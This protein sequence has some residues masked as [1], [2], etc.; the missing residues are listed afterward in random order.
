[1]IQHPE[2][3]IIPPI[4]PGNQRSPAAAPRRQQMNGLRGCPVQR[5]VGLQRSRYD[6]VRPL[7]LVARVSVRRVG[8]EE[9]AQAPP[10]QRLRVGLL[11]P[12]IGEV[13]LRVFPPEDVGE[14]GL[15]ELG[16]LRPGEGGQDPD[17]N[18]IGGAAGVGVRSRLED[19][20]ELGHEFRHLRG[21]PARL[22]AAVAAGGG[23]ATATPAAPVD[24]F[25]AGD[26]DSSHGREARQQ[27]VD[28]REGSPIV[29]EGEVLERVQ[30]F[31]VDFGPLVRRAGDDG[32]LGR[33]RV[34]G[35]IAAGC[36]RASAEK[37]GYYG[38]FRL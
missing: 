36:R 28:V 6:L 21:R 17:D 11:V 33:G 32:E 10:N 2:Q 12:A 4:S 31:V 3:R 26:V 16:R 9:V 1:M 25:C 24:A 7:R 27:C 22:L 18:V 20:H 15:D 14:A 29:Q 23:L 38:C 37:D 30:D 35:G 34:L 13:S 8:V 19:G 5:Q